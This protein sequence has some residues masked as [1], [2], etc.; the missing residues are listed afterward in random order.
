MLRLGMGL[1]RLGGAPS[2]GTILSIIGL[3]YFMVWPARTL[4]SD[5]RGY[6]DA[7]AFEAALTV[8][9]L[10]G[11]IYQII[12]GTLVL[13]FTMAIYRLVQIARELKSPWTTD[14]LATLEAAMVA[15]SRLQT[16]ARDS[17]DLLRSRKEELAHIQELISLSRPQV[18]ALERKLRPKLNTGLG[19]VAVLLSVAG[20]VLV[21]VLQQ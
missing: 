18:S 10:A 9:S 6:S 15:V 12:M 5:A 7:G 1:L 16:Q 2:W 13:G 3:S 4:S 17:T 21:L 14:P 8:L 20:I 19:F 11:A